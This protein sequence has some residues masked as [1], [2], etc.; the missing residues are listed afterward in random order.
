MPVVVLFAAVSQAQAEPSWTLPPTTLS[1]AAPLGWPPVVVTDS[2]GDATALYATASS[3]APGAETL[4]SV[5]HPLGGSWK[6]P[7]TVPSAGNAAAVALATSGNG[8]TTAVWVD[9]K[10]GGPSQVWSSNRASGD[11]WSAPFQLPLTGATSDTLGA[12]GLAEDAQGNV[13]AAWTESNQQHTA[14]WLLA[15]RR[16]NGVWSAPRRL[17]DAGARVYDENPARVSVD[18]AGEF[19]VAWSQFLAPSIISVDAEELIGE[20]WEGEQEITSGG[21]YLYSVALSENAAGEATAAWA[22]LQKG[23]L[24]AATLRNGAWSVKNPSATHLYATCAT[25]PPPQVGVDSAGD[26]LLAWVGGSGQVMAQDLSAEGTWT[27]SAQS[28]SNVP[29]GGHASAPRVSVDPAGDALV[30]WTAYDPLTGSRSIEAAWRAAGGGWGA[31]VT[32]SGPDADDSAPSLSMDAR[33]NAVAAW[34]SSSANESYEIQAAGFEAAPVLNGLQLPLRTTARQGASFSANTSVPW[35]TGGSTGASDRWSF[36]DGSV[37]EGASVS[38]AYAQ[39]GT[40]TVTLTVTDGLLNQTTVSRQVTV[41]SSPQAYMGA[42]VGGA[43]APGSE[44]LE[45]GAPSLAPVYLA[46]HRQRLWISRGSRTASATIHNTNAV[47]VTGTVNLFE[48]PT[49][50]SAAIVNT[51]TVPGARALAGLVRFNLPAHTSGVIVFRLGRAA[52]AR[53]RAQA[54]AKGHDL[55]Q[56]R[57][58]IGGPSGQTATALGT[59][60]LDGPALTRA[61]SLPATGARPGALAPPGA[62]AREAC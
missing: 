20:V 27:G 51:G 9:R 40:Y 1:P 11:T 41:T 42:A 62:W 30:S 16:T 32:L 35:G 55:V 10:T 7:L 26:A 25:P 24:Q 37:A 48:G 2:A 49:A 19:V 13:V 53:L 56:V 18:G 47:P 38:H 23:T 43:T 58:A 57:V 59:Y 28:I 61:V 17:S 34:A 36:G 33:G 60:A 22:D 50:K 46:T 45:T 6:T 54:P 5:D 44:A 8:D 29:G 31:P 39:P 14:T 3:R 15:S 4:L 52:L 12:P 21:D